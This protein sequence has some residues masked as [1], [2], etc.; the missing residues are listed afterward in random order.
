MIEHQPYCEVCGERLATLKTDEAAVCDDCFQTEMRSAMSKHLAGAERCCAPIRDPHTGNLS[1][2]LVP[3][4]EPHSHDPG[5]LLRRWD[6]RLE[7]MLRTVARH[8]GDVC[9]EASNYPEASRVAIPWQAVFKLTEALT[10]AGFDME[11]AKRY[12][13]GDG[14]MSDPTS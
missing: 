8:A 10:A 12:M 9:L 3:I 1:L 13:A 7:E 14:D 6:N 5:G 4:G 11:A 2:C